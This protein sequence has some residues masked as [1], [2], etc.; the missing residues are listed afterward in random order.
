MIAPKQGVVEDF[1]GRYWSVR[2]GPGACDIHWL[3]P[4][5]FAGGDGP[6]E[7]GE[8]V[9]LRYEVTPRSGLWIADR[10]VR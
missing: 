8:P 7:R 1:D 4:F 9:V 5:D 2:F 6:I 10:N 3:R